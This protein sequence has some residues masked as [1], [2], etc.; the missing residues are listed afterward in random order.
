MAVRRNRVFW[1]RL[2]NRQVFLQLGILL[3]S[4]VSGAWRVA[5][6]EAA[7]LAAKPAETRT[8]IHA[9]RL[10]D[11]LR[12]SP[13]TEVT[14]VVAG[15][16]IAEVVAGYL[17]PR[18][19]DHVVD[20]KQST[21]LPGLMDMHTHLS[22][23]YSP[24]AFTERA[25]MDSTEMALRGTM[26]ARRTLN[27]GFTT[28][29][30]LGDVDG[31][32]IALRN[33]IRQGWTDGPRIYTAGKSIATTGGH[34]DPTNGLNRHF[35]GDPGPADGVVNGPEEAMKAIRQRYKE[36][37]DLIK[38]TATGGVLSLAADGQNPQFTD[39]E[40]HAIVLT[41]RDCGF[42]V[43][44]HAHG[45]EGM[46]RAIRAG[47][48]SIEHGTFMDDEAI[49]LMKKHGTWYV[50]TIS[51]GRFVAEKAKIDGYL[52]PIVRPKA[53]AIGPQIDATFAKAYR[54]GVKIAFGT[55]TGVSPH[56]E[57]AK[58]FQYMVEQGMPPLEAIR[59]ATVNAAQ[60]LGVE[61]ELGNIGAGMYADLVA[62]DEDPL[63]DI[64]CL[65][66][67]DFVMKGG[68]VYRS[69]HHP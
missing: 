28:V 41:A 55:D 52:P 43:A 29:R 62:V 6:Q 18:E 27:A 1:I 14:I 65:Q 19:G 38:I 56:G 25:F 53:A 54:A 49:E 16:R 32:T 51:A 58:E 39:A 42:K 45:A 15:E 33:A 31:V 26:Y 64:S 68:V 60:L 12:D 69:G 37:S 2:S 66:R 35:R 22:F 34:A 44:V 36:G 47:V 8:L 50:P 10:I 20:L 57:N 9:G 7:P 13:R 63:Q 5:G 3:W 24:L 4:L 11:P 48:D 67:I 59:T 40:L 61:K 23:E 46:K 17:P 30:D 21:V